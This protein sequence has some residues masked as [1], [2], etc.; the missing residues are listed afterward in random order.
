MHVGIM[1]SNASFAANGAEAVTFAQRA[2][3]LGFESLWASD[4][5][6]VAA[7]QASDYPYA[8]S[9]RYEGLEVPIAEPLVWLAYVAARTSTIRLATGVLVLPQRQVALVAKQVATLDVLAGG[10]TLLGVG[11]GWS[12]EEFTAL[13]ANF[14]DRG[15]RMDDG[16]EALRAMWRPGIASHES[17]FS[18]IPDCFM[19]PS[20]PGGNVPIVIGGHSAAAARRAGRCGD[21]FFPLVRTPDDLAPLVDALSE[22]ATEH[23]RDPRSIEITIRVGPHVDDATL[24]AFR[25]LGVSRILVARTA[26]ALAP[27]LVELDDLTPLLHR[28]R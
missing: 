13:E 1:A 6:L 4:H 21:G 26:S 7:D 9:G 23:G 19:V 28:P 11:V 18:Q 20:P 12:R 2:E 15:E 3:E 25:A 27:A 10:R 14:T 16:I 24:D 17:R 8:R 5:V 22:A